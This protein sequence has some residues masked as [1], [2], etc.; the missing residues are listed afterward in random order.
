MALLI[1]SEGSIGDWGTVGETELSILRT[2]PDFSGLPKP[3]PLLPSPTLSGDSTK[4][5]AFWASVV[6]ILG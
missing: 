5:E 2:N 4:S 3:V 1:L 6:H